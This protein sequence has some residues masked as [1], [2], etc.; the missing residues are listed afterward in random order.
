M[1]L[2]DSGQRKEA[3]E[4]A[5]EQLIHK[6]RRDRLSENEKQE[7][8]KNQHDLEMGTSDHAEQLAILIQERN[9]E[10]RERRH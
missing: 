1:A 3:E 4:L 5:Q 10:I 9:R 8:A 2:L 7:A 6:P